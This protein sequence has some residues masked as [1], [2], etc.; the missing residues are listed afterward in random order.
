MKNPTAIEYD[1]R[2]QPA[3]SRREFFISVLISSGALIMEPHG[4]L[5]AAEPVG[6]RGKPEAFPHKESLPVVVYFRL[7]ENA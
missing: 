2:Q 6:F 3:L 1:N 4:L 7:K 5:V